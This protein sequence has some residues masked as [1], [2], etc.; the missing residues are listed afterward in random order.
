VYTSRRIITRTKDR[1]STSTPGKP[2]TPRLIE[3]ALLSFAL[4]GQ[5]LAACGAPQVSQAND[6]IRVTISADGTTADYQLVAGSTVGD[7]L[8]AAGIV[9]GPLDH[10]SP[11][12]YA[13][14]EDGDAIKVVRVK[15]EFSTVDETV[16]FDQQIVRSEL[17]PVGE[18]RVLQAG[19]NG[20]RELTYRALLEDG[21]ETTR[22]VVKAVMLVQPVPEILLVGSENPFAPL[23]IPG[24]LA[25][26]AGGSAWVMEGS[27]ADRRPV[28]TTGDLDGRVFSVSPGGDWLLFTRR[29]TKPADE[30]IN[31]LWVVSL[32]DASPTPINLLTS[33]VVHFAS[34]VPGS[35]L[36]VAY[37]TVE[38]RAS[39]PGWQANND[40]Y[41]MKFSVTGATGKPAE[42]IAPNAGGVYGWWGTNYVWS[43][44]G[45]RLAYARPD[46]IG[47]VD[48][49]NH[50]LVPLLDIVPL[51]TGSDWTLIP[52]LAWG[53]DGQSL[54]T[55]TH[56]PPQGPL[57]AEVSPDFDLTALSLSNDASV[58]LV[59]ETGMFAYPAS[60]PVAESG[61][62]KSY[63]LSYLQAIFP[64]Q[65]T[66]S[67]YDLVVMDR[68]GSNRRVLFP[69]EGSSGLD[70]Q[71]PAWA[72][73]QL[74][75]RPE[76]FVAVIYQGN[77]WLVDVTS[78]NAYQVTGDGLATRIDWR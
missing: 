4:F 9:L 77:I 46:G 47:L 39:A 22:S 52:G 40:L 60:P 26:L 27:T 33:N 30:E 51:Q 36:T 72:P 17:V 44:D 55:V 71:I 37:S 1:D 64:D 53:A 49:K 25:Y 70:P 31:S 73:S 66:V 78:G 56:A 54:F 74:P 67:R 50:S 57:R 75:E 59:E 16:P 43:P 18:T 69:P 63:S 68:D 14:L 5:L 34:F 38:P 11:E 21:M 62:S 8:S 23:A 29:S 19:Q 48:V 61:A 45:V 10:A 7:A 20:Q 41:F 65:S 24:K 32:N 58:R 28:V 13:T 12:R 3:A 42:I 2:H 15:E 35:A 6:Q 76:Q